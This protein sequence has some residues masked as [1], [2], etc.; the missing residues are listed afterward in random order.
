METKRAWMP[1]SAGLI[2]IL[3]FSMLVVLTGC[4]TDEE[5]SDT[6]DMTPSVTQE[7]LEKEINLDEADFVTAEDGEVTIGMS[8]QGDGSADGI[9]TELSPDEV[10]ADNEV[11]GSDNFTLP[12]AV[13][14]E[15][16]SLGQLS[17]PAIGLTVPIYEA[18]NNELEAMVNGVAHFA[19]TSSW[20]GNVGLA[21]HN[22]GVNTYFQDLYKLQPGDEIILTSALG[23]RTYEVSISKEIDETDWSMLDRTEDN[24]ITLITCVNHDLTKRLC[25]Q[26]IEVETQEAE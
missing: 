3:A 18:E 9:R 24:R 7:E 4:S 12:S 14:L 10:W 23:T 25:V 21:G 6:L 11:T 17:I 22:T 15:D 2:L 16:G 5:G 26:G 8:A 13:Q 1:L 19:E 20:D